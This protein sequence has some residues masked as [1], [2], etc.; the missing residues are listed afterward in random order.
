MEFLS[1]ALIYLIALGG[2]LTL[3]ANT[4]P[5]LTGDIER[6]SLNLEARRV[7]TQLLTEPGHQNF[8]GNSSWEMNDTTVENTVSP[9]IASGFLEVDREKLERLKSIEVRQQGFLDY[10]DFKS[11]TGVEHQYRFRFTWM[12][13][14]ETPGSFTKGNPPDDP[15]VQEPGDSSYAAANNE[16][17][18]GSAAMK[19]N[20]YRFLVVAH[21]ATYDTVYVSRDWDFRSSVAAERGDSFSLYGDNFTVKRFQNREREPG[22]MLV[23]SSHVKTFGA[24]IDSDATVVKLERFASLEGE[25]LKTEV[26][27]W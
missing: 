12:P 16:V 13:I 27:A 1:A 11:S 3:G 18:Y 21:D 7:S 6:S 26:W 2:L 10:S 9:G 5:S 22:A 20:H 24:G 19:G 8:T 23:L 15:P 17:H 25:P 4:L 14:V